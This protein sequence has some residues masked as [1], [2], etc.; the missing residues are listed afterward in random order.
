M[1]AG[2]NGDVTL[3]AK[4]PELAKH[5]EQAFG[6]LLIP[7]LF[8]AAQ[9]V[10][11]CQVDSSLSVLQMLSFPNPAWTDAHLPWYN[12]LDFADIQERSIAMLKQLRYFQSV[13][14]L[15]SFSAAAE[16]NFIS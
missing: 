16:E 14:R 9:N 2:F 15:K 7:S 12:P 3:D 8:H 10:D 5:Y 6:A 4:T 13:V 11:C 1:D